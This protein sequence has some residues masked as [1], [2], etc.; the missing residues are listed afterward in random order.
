MVLGFRKF[1][2]AAIS[3]L[4]LVTPVWAQ[5]PA[6]VARFDVSGFSVLGS[7]QIAG[8]EFSRIVAPFIGRQK[9]IEDVQKAQ[10]AL[11]QAYLDLGH[12][13][14]QVTV[15]KAEPESG[16]VT[17][18]LVQIPTP[19][20]RDCAPTVVLEPSR[21][22]PPVAV[23]PGEVAVRPLADLSGTLADPAA[24]PETKTEIA[25]AATTKP[26][27]DGPVL[28]P[29]QDR[30][31]VVPTIEAAP[32]QREAEPPRVPAKPLADAPQ[33]VVA[34]KPAPAPEPKP[35]VVAIA[36]K[37]EIAPPPVV[38]AVAPKPKPAA[39]PKVEIAP[40]QP[41]VVAVAPKP[42]PVP[43]AKIEVAPAPAA[44]VAKPEPAPEPGPA[45]IAVA[46][47]PEPVLAPKVEVAPAPKPA[48]VAVAPQ[49]ETVL[50]PKVE[51]VPAPKPAVV[52]IAPK[53]APAPAVGGGGRPGFFQ[54]LRGRLPGPGRP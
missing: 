8:A 46:P 13:S 7:P 48:V 49:P 34:A 37:P 4:M 24:P 5:S 17:F 29:L 31:P 38:I 16:V 41:A 47:K 19:L 36:P 12:C 25:R 10:R 9:T 28:K 1:V 3:W 11:Q 14:T 44:V 45:V 53:P 54:G 15:T 26:L 52:A 39:A 18:R 6:A 23:A 2:C 32:V 51:V 33:P 21:A 43:A 50:E 20:S 30:L 40:S 27:L 22:A 35:A 42:E